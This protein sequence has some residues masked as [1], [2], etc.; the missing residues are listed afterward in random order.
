[1]ATVKIIEDGDQHWDQDPESDSAIETR[2]LGTEDVYWD[3]D[4]TDDV[5][6]FIDRLGNERPI[7]G[8]NSGKIPVQTAVRDKLPGAKNIS[9]ALIQLA[10]RSG[11]ESSSSSLDDDTVITLASNLTH[12]QKQALIDVQIRNLGGHVLTVI[13]PESLDLTISSSFVFSGFQ[14]GK[15]VIDL[16]ENELSDAVDITSLILV[17]DCSCHV[18]ISNGSIMHTHSPYGVKGIRSPHIYLKGMRF[19]GSDQADSYAV[20]AEASDGYAEEDCVFDDNEKQ[21]LAAGFQA[22]TVDEHDTSPNPHSG[23][24]A[25]LASPAFTGTPT[26]PPPAAASNNTTIATTAFVKTAANSAVDYHNTADNPHPNVLAPLDSPAFTGTPTAPP[27]ARNSNNNQIAT[28]AFV[29][30]A[31]TGAANNIF[32]LHDAALNPHQ[33]VLAPLDSPEFSGTPTAPT[34]APTSNNTTIATTAFVKTAVA[35]AS[36]AAEAVAAH[37]GASKPHAGIL[38][39]IAH[40]TNLR[41]HR[42]LVPAGV[43]FPYAGAGSI[44]QGFLLCDGM[45]YYQSEYEDLYAAIGITYGNMGTGTFKVPDFRGKFLR[46]YELGLTAAIGTAQAEDFPRWRYG[47]KDISG[48]IS[49]VSGYVE[50]NRSGIGWDKHVTPVNYAIQWIIK[51]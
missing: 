34:A 21:V 2:L 8:I 7:T 45:W 31:A 24:L 3:S 14:N 27:P 9:E 41:A 11:S 38:T 42:E 22:T 33:N 51:Y 12:E 28:T 17:R 36:G 32:D 47:V 46:G 13:F 43:V 23:V 29:S 1:M 26:A 15:L 10:D 5:H 44:P 30:S 18:E 4:G 50:D 39:P 25:P 20:L 49:A 48:S 35:G 16:N 40:T 19:T 37:N 6:S